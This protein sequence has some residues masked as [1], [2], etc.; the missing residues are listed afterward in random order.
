MAPRDA[1]GATTS[2]WASG[3]PGSPT[4]WMPMARSSAGRIQ[5]LLR[6]NRYPQRRLT[7]CPRLAQN[8]APRPHE[9]QVGFAR[10][11]GL[12]LGHQ[13]GHPSTDLAI[14]PIEVLAHQHFRQLDVTVH[15]GVEDFTLLSG[16]L[17]H[18]RAVGH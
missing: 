16:P 12:S 17:L 4:S 14:G 5:F 15:A 9:A 13:P 7:G 1:A 3:Q 8:L 6:L 18:D 10:N 2:N 11:S